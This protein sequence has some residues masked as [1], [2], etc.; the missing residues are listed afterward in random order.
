MTLLVR[1][2]L[3]VLRIAAIFLILGVVAGFL[4]T[5]LYEMAG[6]D[7]YGANN[8]LIGI[9]VFTLIF[10][11]YRNRLQFSGWYKGKGRNRLFRRLT[12]VLV[13]FGCLL[14]LAPVVIELIN[15]I[16]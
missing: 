11:L 5:S 16:I 12:R 8:T 10:V 1:T 15:T 6:I 2:V 9:G 7:L 4:I 3:E 14:I 13:S